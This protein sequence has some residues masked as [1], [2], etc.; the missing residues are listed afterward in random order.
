MSIV[1][2]LVTLNELCGL[3]NDVD[4]VIVAVGD[5]AHVLGSVSPQESI[6]GGEKCTVFSDDGIA[7]D[8]EWKEVADDCRDIELGEA[9]YNKFYETVVHCQIASHIIK[10]YKKQVLESVITPVIPAVL[11]AIWDANGTHLSHEWGFVKADELVSFTVVDSDTLNR[12]IHAAWASAE[13]HRSHM[14]SHV[15]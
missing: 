4:R 15:N 10:H 3:G 1:A 8:V 7:I 9:A 6:A 14:R 12:C 2:K 5:Q 13:M 11:V